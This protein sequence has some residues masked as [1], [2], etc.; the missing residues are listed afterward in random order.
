MESSISNKTSAHCFAKSANND[1]K[2]N[3]IVVFPSNFLYRFISFH[4]RISESEAKYSF[5]IIKT[6]RSDKKRY[7]LVE[8]PQFTF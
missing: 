7:A 6:D 8:F 3:F 1:V 4:D 5:V 2:Q